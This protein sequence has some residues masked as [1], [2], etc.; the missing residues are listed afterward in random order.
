[1]TPVPQ[2]IE[3]VCFLV[4]VGFLF[5]G[6]MLPGKIFKV[7]SLQEKDTFLVAT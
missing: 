7:I 6:L 5:F 1:M 4:V 2:V 3:C